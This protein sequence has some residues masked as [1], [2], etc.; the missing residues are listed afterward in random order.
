[1]GER[2][3]LTRLLGAA[4]VVVALALLFQSVAAITSVTATDR[5]STGTIR[6]TTSRSPRDAEAARA[7]AI[8]ETI[9]SLREECRHASG[10]DWDPWVDQLG[11]FRASLHKRIREAKPYNPEA[12]GTY[13]AR[14]LVLEGRGNFALFESE[15]EG[16]LRYL[17]DTEW[18][19]GFR[20]R[21]P[22]VAAARWLKSQ[23]VDVIFV[24]VPKMTEVYAERFADNCPSDQIVA[25]QVRRIMLELLESDV[26][27][28]DLL[29]SFLEARDKDPA[30]L[31]QPADPHWAPRAWGVAAQAVGKRLKRYPFV[32]EALES[33]RICHPAEQA[34]RPARQGAT[35][36]ALTPDQRRRAEAVQPGTVQTVQYGT[37]SIVDPA[38]SVILIGDSYNFG[39]CELL[40][41]EIN[42]PIVNLAAGGQTT[43]AFN[44]FLRAPES[45][46]HCKV[47]VWLVCSTSLG[48]E[49]PL[50]KSILKFGH[51]A[52][53]L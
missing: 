48:R 21:R 24:P 53:A 7:A 15:P 34:F 49:W 10:G 23:G 44:D 26:E 3:H 12:E 22:V 19:E 52:A 16:Y 6:P 36:L 37:S 46:K 40:S 35:Y 51:G 42:L 30:P 14:S 20:N 41:L 33:A 18:L 38:S 17:Y 50:P 4:S 5:V 45:L 2:P 8:R 9:R 25:P 11:P 29:P 13:E 27:I 28:V 39:F 31:Y 1:M 32:A 47:V 43:Q